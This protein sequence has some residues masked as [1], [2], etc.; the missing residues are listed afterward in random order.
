MRK[1][2]DH[3]EADINHF[4]HGKSHTTR[5]AEID[6]KML[7]E[8]YSVSNLHKNKTRPLRT[9]DKAKD[10]LALGSLP[11]KMSDMLKGWATRRVDEASSEQCYEGESTPEGSVAG[12][13]GDAGD[14][15]FDE[16]FV[17]HAEAP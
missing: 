13:A 3:V 5:S 11:S 9:S 8:A 16:D 17:M 15:D 6:I 14:A 4:H 1:V 12:D 10:L 2:K 7:H